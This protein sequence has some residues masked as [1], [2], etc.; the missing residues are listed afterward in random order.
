[1][2]EPPSPTPIGRR[3]HRRWILLALLLV[4]P[5]I[6][7]EVVVRVLI[8]TGRMAP[9]AAH[10]KT[11]EISWVDLERAGDVDVLLLGASTMHSGVDPAVLG[12]LASEALGK[13]VSVFNLGIPGLG[14]EPSLLEQ[15]EREGRLPDAVVVGLSASGFGNQAE[16]TSAFR[17]SP[18]GRYFS[19]CEG[20]GVEGY[21]AIVDCQAS[22]YSALW[23]WRGYADEIVRAIR[24][25]IFGGV[26]NGRL[27]RPDGFSE[28]V[29][30]SVEKI[31]GQIEEGLRSQR[32]LVDV[33]PGTI[34][35]YSEIAEF[36]EAHGIPVIGITIP[37]APPF[38]DATEVKLPGYWAS[39]QTAV[40][41]LSD[42]SG[43][44]FIKPALFGSW[45]G[46]GSSQNVKHLSKKGAIDFT[47]QLWDTPEF[48]DQ[49]L[50]SLRK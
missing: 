4:I 10:F 5:V 29:P 42:G 25:P 48:R 43:I 45:W 50:E 49:L 30:R 11:L 44:P 28:G 8:E 47:H 12:E 41:K 9:A 27:R 13:P 3:R 33:G 14:G 40:E 20:G 24:K 16:G 22:L 37:Y 19:R 15:L 18:M 1:M 26:K 31:E 46:D 39:W 21:E 38:M 23:R 7:G 2:I 35:R 34:G 32:W 36:L 6:V 17:Y